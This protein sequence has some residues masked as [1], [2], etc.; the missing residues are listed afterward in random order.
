MFIWIL[1]PA[2]RSACKTTYSYGHD[3]LVGC[4]TPPYRCLCGHSVRRQ[5]IYR[6]TTFDFNVFCKFNKL[7]CRLLPCINNYTIMRSQNIFQFWERVVDSLR[8]T[9]SFYKEGAYSVTEGSILGNYHIV[10]KGE[11]KNGKRDIF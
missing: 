2:F 7:R 3:F 6:M 10:R 5:T 11:G 8:Y 9:R 1:S 4:A